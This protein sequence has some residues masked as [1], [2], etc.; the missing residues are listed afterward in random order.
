[1][2]FTSSSFE[3]GGEIP[4]KFTCDGDGINPELEI[5]N[6]P[7]HAESLALILHDPD[8]PIA[9]GFHALGSL[10]YRSE[11]NVHQRGKCSPGRHGRPEG[12]P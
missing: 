8:A 5:H 2:L 9:G 4:K 6:A 1:M 12:R 7:E 3:D 11:D 10:E